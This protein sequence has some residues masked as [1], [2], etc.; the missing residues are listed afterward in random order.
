MGMR[1]TQQILVQRALASLRNQTARIAHLQEQLATGQRVMKPSDDPLDARR[2]MNL[3][4]TIGRNEQYLA[5][6]QDTSP[7]L[8]ETA[9]SIENVV[10]SLQRVRELTL[11]GA[12]GTNT[13]SQTASMANEVNQLLE[14]ILAAANHQTN[15]R[16]IF[17]GTNTL[18]PPFAA[19]RDANDEVVSVSYQGNSQRFEVAVGDG[20][21]TSIGET[22]DTVFQGTQDI[23]QLVMNIRDSLRNG[24]QADLQNTRLPELDAA[25]NQL[26]RALARIGGV[27]NR[28]ERSEQDL[29]DFNQQLET[30][31]SDSVDADFVEV[32]INL[33]TQNNAYLAAL[34]ATSRV[35]QPSLMD[36][37]S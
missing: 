30:V 23:L 18:T 13:T 22:G 25:Q 8:T 12:S 2:A 37:L 11:Q 29:E 20:I 5:T 10:E 35:L 9:M 32:T 19:T 36:Y 27:Q 16:Y 21:R 15:S 33:N 4:T 1:I 14:A 3:R 6:M 28:L 26:L 34:N 24:D 31:L 7:V 17:G